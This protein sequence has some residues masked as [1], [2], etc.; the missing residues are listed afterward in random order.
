MAAVPPYGVTIR[1]A[2][3]SGDLDRMKTAAAE[4]E[5]HLRGF[6]NVAAALEVL[7]L[8]IAKLEGRGRKAD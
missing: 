3:A 2:V 4:A 8:E 1:D 6:G 5:E 7:K